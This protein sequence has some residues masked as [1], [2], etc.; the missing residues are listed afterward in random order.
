ML[1]VGGGARGAESGP[2]LDQELEHAVKER[3]SVVP[4]SNLRLNVIE[5]DQEEDD[6]K[7]YPQ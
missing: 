2:R 1:A 3:P 4:E 5:E 6:I 7:Y